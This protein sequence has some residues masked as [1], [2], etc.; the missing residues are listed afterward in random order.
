MGLATGAGRRMGQRVLAWDGAS[1]FIIKMLYL[2]PT[3]RNKGQGRARDAAQT[4]EPLP[5][6]HESLGS[7]PQHCTSWAWRAVAFIPAQ[8]CRGTRRAMALLSVNFIT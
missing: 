5:S 4:A 8:S 3:F 7:I 6:L 2:K 1:I